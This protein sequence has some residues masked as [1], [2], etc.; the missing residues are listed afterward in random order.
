[1]KQLFNSPISKIQLVFGAVS[2]FLIS[3]INV[4]AQTWDYKDSGTDFILLDLSIPSGQDQVAYAAGSLYTVDSEGIIIKTVDGG[5]SWETIYPLTG[6]VSSFT[7]IEF[8][9]PLK[10][11]AV[12]WGNTF[13]V[14]E[15]GGVTW[16]DVVEG[17]GT[18]VYYYS[19]L[20]F[21][22]EDVG[23]AIALNNSNGVD[24]YR[25]NDGG[26]TWIEESDTAEMAEFAASFAD[27][28]TLFSVG[29]DQVISKSE[30]GG[31]NWSIISTGIQ[32]F[33]NFEVF[34]KDADNGIVSTEDGTLLTTHDSGVTWDA[35]STGYHNFYGLNYI[36]DQLYAA[37]T[38]EDVFHSSDNGITWNLVHDGPPTAT[39][40]A[41][42]FFSNGDA[43]I[44][45]SQGTMLK[46][47]ELILD[48]SDH[49][50]SELKTIYNSVSKELSVNSEIAITNYLIY[51]LDGKLINEGKV[52]SKST[53]TIDVS[54]L[55][56]GNYILLLNSDYDSKSVKFLKY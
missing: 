41:I 20:T 43:L 18:N 12:G 22:N 2:L 31:D 6:T 40:Y 14:T 38:D 37:G 8:V 16:Q 48:N 30:D 26:S 7:K 44:C 24:S 45:G 29:K 34:F 3:V 9:T 27:E 42:E 19:S 50:I 52:T 5:E 39:F 49:L 32:G 4:N 56:N 54:F 46:A 1:M 11:F 55:S 23:F 17:T 10:G 53:L 28:T 21:Y 15:D 51:S 36:G 13:M 35:F 25:T 47:S 33:Y